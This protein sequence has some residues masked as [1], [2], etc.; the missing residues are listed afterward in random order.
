MALMMALVIA[1]ANIIA[2]CLEVPKSDPQISSVV[3]YR[4]IPGITAA[5][6]AEIASLK[7]SRRSLSFAALASDEIFALS[8]GRLSGFSVLLCEFLSELFEIPFIPEINTWDYIKSGLDNKTIDFTGEMTP[9][10]ERMAVYHMTHPITARSLGIITRRDFPDIVSEY[11]L[12]GMKIGVYENTI[13]AESILNIYHDLQIEI[14]DMIN[15]DDAN[16]KLQS[17]VIDAYVVEADDTNDPNTKYQP[18]FP[19]VYTPVSLTTA[20]DQLQVIISVLD[21]YITAGGTDRLHELH[22]EGGNLHR[23]NLLSRSF[24]DEERAYIDSLKGSKVPIVM[25]TD[26]YPVSFYNDKEKEFQGISMDVFNRISSLTGIEFEVINSTE[27]SWGG[28]LDLLQSGQAAMISDLIKTEERKEHFIWSETPFYSTPY[29]FISKTNFQNLELYQIEQSVVGVVEWCATRDLYDQWFPSN[30]KTKLYS[31]QDDALDALES[32]EIDLFF[33]LGYILL[34]QRSYRERHDYKANYTFPVMSD[35]FFGFNKN[36]EILRSV[37]DKSMPHTDMEAIARDWSNRIYDYSI[38]LARQQSTYM[39]LFIITLLVVIAIITLLAANIERKKRI[40]ARQTNG[41]QEAFDQVTA[42]NANMTV[43][44]NTMPVGIRIVSQEDGS[45]IYA[46]KAS[47]DIFGCEDFERDVAG[48]TAFD[49][50]PEI[51]PNGRTTADMAAEFFANNFTTMDFECFKLDG[52]T[53]TARITS[54]NVDYMDKLSSLAIIEDITARKQMEESLQNSLSESQRAQEALELQRN[55]L[56]TMIDSMPDFVFGK[57]LDFEYT[58][59]NQSA[60]RYLN[61][62]RDEVIGKTDVHGLNFPAEIA[63][64]MVEQDKRIFGGEEKFIDEHWIPSY[65]GSLRYYETTKAPI[66]QNGKII[67]LVGTSRDITEKTRMEKALQEETLKAQ[68]ASEAKSN[69]LSVMSHEMR[70]PLN[71]IVGMTSIGKETDQMQRKDYAL[72]KIEDASASLL[73]I[74]NDVLDM[75]KIEANKLELSPIEFNLK[76]M[77]QKVIS[78]VKFRMDEKQQRF[79]MRIDD[80]VPVFIMGDDQRLSQVVTNLLTNASKFTHEGGEINMRVSLVKEKK[81]ICELR[82]EIDDN[83]IGISPEQQKKLFR[84][85]LQAESG[86]SRT[87]GGTGLGLALSK[88]IVELMGGK[89]W[90]DSQLGKGA[91][92]LFTIKAKRIENVGQTLDAPMASG[93]NIAEI[94]KQGDFSGVR[95]LLA[96]DI[97]INREIV[98]S[99]LENTG[100]VIDEADNGRIAYEMI[101]ADPELY[102]LVFMD[103]QMPGMDGL[104]ATKKIRTLPDERAK[105]LPIIAMTANVFKEDIEKCLAAGMDDH[106]GKPL[107]IDEVIAVLKKY[108]V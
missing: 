40:I 91:K 49:F 18:L 89:I 90:V 22:R 64:I 63:E 43:V 85:F 34:Y 21:K 83:G 99:L 93:K 104:E 47:M 76:R 24:T 77:L 17:G 39:V 13:T 38:A 15:S 59:L 9:T 53:F 41:L 66:I 74:I 16:Q 52:E 55:T 81:D 92:F 48:K 26:T 37:I 32:G 28:I 6:T 62:D 56:R 35:I 67:G 69:F 42:V 107:D 94:K 8:D 87:F 97:E 65:D 10:P 4:D 58:L 57:N 14:I 51:Q 72:G 50:M 36:Q 86:I 79:D 20:N 95:L 30:T 70:T 11:E 33:N 29:M 105:K 98:I 2:G 102:S 27:H 19:L 108:S 68:Q 84:A 45:L 60:A 23:R 54:C 101:K 96:E 25:G 5:E 103:M 46:N 31:S 12:N 80:N 82:F 100:L 106:I 71:A 78:I 7:E 3:S 88:R 73:G 61:V 44:L 1:A 75:A